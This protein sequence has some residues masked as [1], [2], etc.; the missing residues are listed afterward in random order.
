MAD[1]LDGRMLAQ[2]IRE[3]LTRRVAETDAVRPGL[4]LIRVGEDPASRIY[5][6]GKEK[7][8]AEV[9]IDS[10]VEVLPEDTSEAALL[11]RIQTANE[12]PAVHGL[13]VQ[14]PLPRPLR[15]EVIAE[16]VDP[17]KDVDG[18]HPMNQ[19]RLALGRPGLI[20]CTPLGVLTLL[21]R[22]RI[23]VAGRRVAVLGRSAIVGRPM[24]LLLSQKAVWADATVTL[25]HSGSRDLPDITREA[26]IVIA[27][28]GRVRAVTAEMIRPGAVVVDVGMH[29]LEDPSAPR[30]ERLVGD[31]DAAGVDRVASWLSPVPGG[32]GPLTVAMLLANTVTA[33]EQSRGLPA[34]PIWEALG[35]LGGPVGRAGAE[36]ER[37]RDARGESGGSRG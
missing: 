12:D 32:V 29:R 36:A 2:E 20:P 7:A 30:G 19:G 24:S 22:Y 18:L 15:P 17:D 33:W 3:H 6:R 9:G 34:W 31:V 11:R 5:V 1:R 35:L 21:H 27:A 13:L 25:C 37:P 14:L 10:R 23:P 4:L 8:A 16:A 28:M 26:D